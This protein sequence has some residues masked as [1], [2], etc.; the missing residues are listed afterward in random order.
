[1]VAGEDASGVAGEVVEQAELG[2]GGGNALSAHSESHGGGIDLDF[3][4]LQGTRRQWAL[5]AAQYGLD[6]GNEFTRAEGLGKVVVGAEFEAEDA[7]RFAALCCQKDHGNSG[8]AG[9]LADGAA[10][11]EPVFA[12]NHNVE[13]EERGTLSLSVGQYRGTCGIDAHAKV[14]IFEVVAD[15]AGNVGVVLY[16]EDA[17]LH[18]SIAAVV[19]G[20]LVRGS[21]SQR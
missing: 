15:Q 13:N 8:Q 4:D 3:A 18:V 2:R 17:W 7:V 12:G 5:K 11:F 19:S 21:G 16:N 6:S 14:V 10:E 20:L 1:M 9:S